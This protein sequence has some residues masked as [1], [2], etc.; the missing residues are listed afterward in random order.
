MCL[1]V[2]ESGI[3]LFIVF[4][5]YF[6]VWRLFWVGFR[7]VYFVCSDWVVCFCFFVLGEGA[8][9]F[10]REVFFCSLSGLF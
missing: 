6:Y 9:R 7:Y 8:F 4:R 10:E 1:E 2:D 3:G 5:W